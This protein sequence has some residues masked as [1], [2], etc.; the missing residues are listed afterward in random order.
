M[1]PFLSIYLE[2]TQNVNNIRDLQEPVLRLL[3]KPFISRQQAN[4]YAR[5]DTR[6]STT[7]KQKVLHVS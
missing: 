5:I 2:R 1:K 3:S 6:N 7:K 4:R